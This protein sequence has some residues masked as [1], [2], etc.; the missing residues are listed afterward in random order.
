M[1][2]IWHGATRAQNVGLLKSRDWQQE[3]PYKEALE[4]VRHS[5]DLRFEGILMRRAYEAVKSRDW[6]D[7]LE[8]L[9]KGD[10]LSMW[11][12]VKVRE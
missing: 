6:K 5:S 3:A 10:R 2:S 1:G 11:A 4:F 8:V 12:S 9:L 7:Y